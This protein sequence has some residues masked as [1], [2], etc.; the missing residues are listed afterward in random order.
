MQLILDNYNVWD[1]MRK[2]AE[3]AL[4]LERT[5]SVV[6]DLHGESPDLVQT[7]LPE[8]FAFLVKMG[9]DVSKIKLVTGNPIE[10]YSGVDVSVDYSA[11]YE[12]KLFQDNINKIS[13][14]KK[15]KYHFGNFVS[16]ANLPRLILGSHLYSNYHDKTLQ[17]FHY[18]NNSHY[19]KNYAMLDKVLN[20]YGIHSR[21]FVE[22]CELL[23]NCPL[24]KDSVDYPILVV[25]DR[26]ENLLNPCTW[27]AEI[28]V[29][30][31]CE[32]WYT[33]N[34]F[35][36]TEK[37]WRSVVTKTPFILQGSQHIITNL[38]KLGFKTFDKY[39]DEGYQEDPS[40]YNLN[41]IKKIIQFIGKKSI[42]ELD[43]M[44]NDMQDILEHNRALFL[45]MSAEDI[46]R[47]SN[48]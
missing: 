39:W 34:S 1:P 19:H 14:D 24:T 16:K 36:V 27:Y 2:A 17:T 30:V 26:I 38:K 32:T 25:E 8:F 37:F 28:F 4:E 11:F 41:E 18:T 12:I 3:I 21:E 47:V 5:G 40:Y 43:A 42:Q 23:K 10:N 48:V 33:G 31:I 6:I 46:K 44:Y 7:V 9:L 13:T 20:E 22:A 35:Y 45:T 15:I 29:D